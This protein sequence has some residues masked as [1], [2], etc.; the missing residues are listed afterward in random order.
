MSE[1]WEVC[2]NLDPRKIPEPEIALLL[3]AKDAKFLLDAVTQKAR[4]LHYFALKSRTGPA[5]AKA[6]QAHKVQ[7]IIENAI[8]EGEAR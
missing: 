6:A 1:D 7:E 3:A 2:G 5:R 8:K 4:E